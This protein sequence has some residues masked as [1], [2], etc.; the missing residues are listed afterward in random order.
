VDEQGA[1][2]ITVGAGERKDPRYTE[3]ALDYLHRNG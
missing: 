1:T 3:T 2:W